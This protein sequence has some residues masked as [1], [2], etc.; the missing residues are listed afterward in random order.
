[1][2]QD[3]DEPCLHFTT[4]HWSLIGRAGSGG[5]A[6]R[7]AALNQLL[8]RYLPALRAHLILQ[9]HLQDAS[10][11]DLLHDFILSK[12][13]LQEIIRQA[14]PERG[15]FRDFLLKALTYFMID[16]HR[17]AKA[18]K[19]AADAAI[20][21]NENFDAVDNLIDS[22]DVFDVAWARQLLTDA[23]EDMRTNCQRDGR[24][25]IWDIFQGRLLDPLL[26]DAQPVPYKVLVARHRLDSPDTA[27]NLL[28]TARR[29]FKK[30]LWNRI[31]EYEPDEEMIKAEIADLLRILSGDKN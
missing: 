8:Q 18:Q 15:R 19:R 16:Q 17:R 13:V 26:H 28:E 30:S 3:S 7:K 10:A 20:P 21:I 31:A 6:E 25:D 2:S 9:K 4:T 29:R 1:M 23:I 11:D 27:S 12:D 24:L 5:D 22:R 14:K